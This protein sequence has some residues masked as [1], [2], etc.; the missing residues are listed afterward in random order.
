MRTRTTINFILFSFAT[1]AIMTSCGGSTEFKTDA[2]TG[3]QYRFIK[4][5]DNGAKPAENS[6]AKIQMLWTG[7]NTK[8]DADTVFID[9]HK[10]GFG[11]SNGVLMQAIQLKKSFSGCLEQGIMMMSK[12]DSAVF[13]I[14]GDSLYL[15]TFRF[16]KERLPAFLK[17]NPT[18]TFSIKLVSFQTQQERQADMQAEMQKRMA[19]AQT[20][21]AQE[22]GDIAAFLQKNYPNVKPD[23]DSIF[24]L[25][26]IKGKGRQVKEGDS[27]QV[28]YTGMFLDG[29]IFDQS[30]KGAGHRTYGL[31][32]SKDQNVIHVIQGWIDV[33][34]K[35]HEGDKV[36]VLI[37]SSLAYGQRG[38]QQIQPYTPLIFDMELVSVKSGK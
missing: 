36:K 30:D 8:G 12:G 28:G 35:M 23:A 34:G 29:K 4:H 15:K 18:F 6:F 16:P 37:P 20:M 32:Y 11:D 38:M 22:P 19:A 26:S 25:E 2:T 14:N 21:K 13:K 7:K 3:V 17:S 9:S 1:A 10:K 5:D 31:K 24:Y 27:I 33:L